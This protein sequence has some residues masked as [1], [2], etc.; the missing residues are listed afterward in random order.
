MR[1]TLRGILLLSLIL[2]F[3][4]VLCS[5]A[6]AD[7]PSPEPEIIMPQTIQ[8]GESVTVTI[9]NA[10]LFSFDYGRL[11]V[12]K[13]NA[14]FSSQALENGQATIPAYWFDPGEYVFTF[15][16]VY[17]ATQETFS[18]SRM[19]TVTGSPGA[20]G[21][22]ITADHTSAEVNEDVMFTVHV[23]EAEEIVYQYLI[24]KDGRRRSTSDLAKEQMREGTITLCRRSRYDDCTL[25]L[26]A[27]VLVNGQWTAFS[28]CAV[29]INP[30]PKLDIP[31][32]EVPMVQLA[33]EPVAIDISPV[34][35]AENYVV[36]IWQDNRSVKT[37]RYQEAG[38]Y[39]LDYVFSE[40]SYQIDIMAEAE[41]Y[42]S[43]GRHTENIEIVSKWMDGP[44]LTA[45]REI[46]HPTMQNAVL[47]ASLDGAT[48]FRFRRVYHDENGR[49]FTPWS[50]ADV[51]AAN[52]SAVYHCGIMGYGDN[53]TEKTVELHAIAYVNGRWTGEKVITVTVL[54]LNR[55]EAPT[56]TVPSGQCEAGRPVVITVG[57]EKNTSYYVY[58]DQEGTDREFTFTADTNTETD[59][60][61][62]ELIGLNEPGTYTVRAVA[63]YSSDIP[64]AAQSE[65]TTAVI[66]LSGSFPAEGPRI[67]L[68]ETTIP[69]QYSGSANPAVIITAYQEGAEDYY[70][71]ITLLRDDGSIYIKGRS[72]WE[73]AAQDGWLNTK[74]YTRSHEKNLTFVVYVSALVNGHWTAYSEKRITLGQGG[75]SGLLPVTFSLPASLT[76]IEPSAFEGIFTSAVY[77][78]DNCVFIN[79]RA[80]ADS[81]IQQIRLP[82][83]CSIADTAFDG[84]GHLS[85]ITAPGGG[86]SQTWA[87]NY[88]ASHSGCSFVEE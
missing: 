74:T 59:E 81:A 57:G 19:V 40:G 75:T 44:E 32:I 28:S 71:N 80:F 82:K 27:K 5:I 12:Y 14:I 56:L 22:S 41:G 66:V 64:N 42:I 9:L 61:E 10:E 45:D 78:P 67:W 70:C 30:A 23:P 15:N 24:I 72:S 48:R 60:V 26:Y 17:L 7:D 39:I 85:V 18:V 86:T 43:D 58:V 35:Y 37:I 34:D 87:E 55:L 49:A 62:L 53:E 6:C 54:A 79:S 8:R 13:N 47:T 77:V 33:G 16:G 11:I 65:E 25:Y 63:A 69:S 38:T 84:C 2:V 36:T 76:A 21:P 46:Y 52:G 68:R 88:I 29:P 31:E 73:E 3:I 83:N 20:E 50:D 51:Q 1:K 4:A